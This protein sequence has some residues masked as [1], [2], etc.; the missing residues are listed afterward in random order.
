[1]NSKKHFLFI[2]SAM[3]IIYQGASAQYG[4]RH[5]EERHESYYR[6]NYRNDYGYDR[7]YSYN[8]PHVSLGFGGGFDG[9]SRGIFYRPYGSYFS[10]TLPSF[11]IR[12]RVLPTGYRRIYAGPHEYY[13]YD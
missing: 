8:R 2:L 11:G 3:L 6:N 13:Y 9:Y 5:R 4:R 12:V 10:L 1:M 7:Y